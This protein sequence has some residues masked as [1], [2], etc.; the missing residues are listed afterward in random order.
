MTDP[1]CPAS[2]AHIRRGQQRVHGRGRRAF[3]RACGR[4]RG[5]LANVARLLLLLLLLQENVLA[6]SAMMVPET[7]QRLEAALSEL[8]LYLVSHQ[9]PHAYRMHV[10]SVHASAP[11]ACVNTGALWGRADAGALMMLQRP[12][13]PTFRR[14]LLAPRP[15]PSLPSP[16]HRAHITVTVAAGQRARRWRRRR[17]GPA[18]TRGHCGCSGSGCALNV[19]CDVGGAHSSSPG[20]PCGGQRSVCAGMRYCH[21]MGSVASTRARPTGRKLHASRAACVGLGGAGCAKKFVV[22]PACQRVTPCQLAR[23]R[24]F[25][26]AQPRYQLVHRP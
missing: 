21:T 7:R 8:Q 5:H 15:S 26:A 22:R 25:A 17:G 6:E 24:V 10:G 18:R 13:V 12:S 23:A 1:S 2:P 16:R 4:G 9:G 11:H 14:H 3:R 20:Q 19:V